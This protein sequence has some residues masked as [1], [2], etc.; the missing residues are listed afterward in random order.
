MPDVTKHNAEQER[1]GDNREH[2]WVDFLEHWDS[3]GVYN[4]LEGSREIIKFDIGRFFDCVIFPSLHNRS[5]KL[6]N[7]DSNLLFL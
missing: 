3:I 1:E 4:L 7:G 2:S 5:W 6:P